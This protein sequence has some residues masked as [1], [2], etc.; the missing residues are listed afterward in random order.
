MNKTD[1]VWSLYGQY[2]IQ[3]S[4]HREDPNQTLQTDF[5]EN[6]I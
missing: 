4:N 2:K 5:T 3:Y 6:E 1:L